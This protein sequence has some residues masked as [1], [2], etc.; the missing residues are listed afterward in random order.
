MSKSGRPPIQ[1]DKGKI[2]NLYCQ[3][4]L[5][6]QQIGPLLGV[7]W[8]TI[9]RRLQSWGIPIR[10]QYPAWNKG[11]TTATDNRVYRNSMKTSRMSGHRHTPESKLNMSISRKGQNT[12]SRGRQLSIETKAKIGETSK[13]HWQ[14]PEY[15]VKVIRGMIRGNYQRPTK[16]EQRLIDIIQKYKLP[17]EYTGDGSFL[18]HGYSPDF[19]NCNGK[20]EIIEVFGDYWHSSER[21]QTTWKRTELG[22]IMLFNSF[23]FRCIVLWERELNTLTDDAIVEKIKR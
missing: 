17:F 4:G 1:L 14:D 12:W 6:C 13:Q 3:Q 22:R 19:V 8:A 7:S 18:I 23:G 10:H 16:P 2:I 9:N 11:L 5:S 20:K 15:R 21:E